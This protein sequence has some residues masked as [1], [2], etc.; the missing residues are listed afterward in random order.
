MKMISST[1]LVAILLVVHSDSV[2]AVQLMIGGS[3]LIAPPR[4][5]SGNFFWGVTQEIDQTFSFT[6]ISG[7]TFNVNELQ[8]PLWHYPGLA[9]N[10]A[11]FSVHEDLLGEPG[12]VVGEFLVTGI[13]TVEQLHSVS[14]LIS[15]TLEGN[16]KYWIAGDSPFGQVNW[17]LGG[18]FGDEVFGEVG[19]RSGG[20]AWTI[21]QGRN[22]SAF[23]ISGTSVPEPSSGA[24]FFVVCIV[25][26][27]RRGRRSRQVD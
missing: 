13:S 22:V 14:P 18:D 26:A 9:G 15:F 12:A 16:E 27:S 23:A 11:T 19:F 25:G 8:I 7:D 3:E 6:T 21:Q 1:Y 17:N 5:L 20:G 24:I 4:Y 2:L 10:T